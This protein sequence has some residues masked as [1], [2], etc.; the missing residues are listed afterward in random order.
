[1]MKGKPMYPRVNYEM[2]EEDLKAIL[3]ACKPVPCMMIGAYAPASLQENA[4]RAWSSL[5]KKMGFDPM[6]VQPIQGKGQRFFSAIPTETEDQRKEREVAEAKRKR[7][8]RIEK[9][10]AQISDLSKELAALTGEE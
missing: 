2:T 5:G 7:E 6:T 3:D 10:R 4:N 1:M 8:D 9:L